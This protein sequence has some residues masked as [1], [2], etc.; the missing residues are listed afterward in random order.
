MP[1]RHNL[2]EN[3]SGFQMTSKKEMTVAQIS[4]AKILNG[5]RKVKKD[6]LLEKEKHKTLIILLSAIGLVTFLLITACAL[7]KYL[8]KRK[9]KGKPRELEYLENE[10]FCSSQDNELFE[11]EDVEPKALI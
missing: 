11:L 8:I 3:F 10:I 5:T 9:S 2:G 1:N 7:V 6:L 4:Y